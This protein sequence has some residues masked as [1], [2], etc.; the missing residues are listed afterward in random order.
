MNFQIKMLYTVIISVVCGLIYWWAPWEDFAQKADIPGAINELDMFWQA[1]DEIAA[2][3]EKIIEHPE[4]ALVIVANR[5]ELPQVAL[6]VEG[7]P[8][9]VMTEQIVDCLTKHKANA[10][11]FAEGMNAAE[12]DET[13]KLITEGGF[14]LGNYTFVGTSRL[15]RQPITKIIGEL[16]RTQKVIRAQ[17]GTAPKLFMA[18]RTVYTPDVLKAV[19]ACGLE[20]AVRANVYIDMA[21]I[22]S[23]ADADNFALSVPNGS[24]LSMKL[25]LTVEPPAKAAVPRE[26]RPAIDKKPTIKDSTVQKAAGSSGPNF[27]ERL[28]YILTAFDKKGVVFANVNYFSKIKYIPVAPM[29]VEEDA[30]KAVPENGVPAQ[31]KPAGN[32]ATKTGT[33]A[34]SGASEEG[35]P[36]D[37]GSSEEGE[38]LEED[39]P[40][41]GEP[42]EP[43]ED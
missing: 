31:G 37:N 3:R 34:E 11:F 5:N 17:T 42:E 15:D 33:P 25:G 40:E 29:E 20:A 43:A 26:Q 14:P 4:P 1:D 27:A 35:A 12:E 19:N 10:V 6:V 41:E 18:N 2:A 13:I 39:V 32:V 8:D 22:N 28:E 16:C 21:T 7:L 24:I 23:Q 30:P 9:R 38:P 36:T